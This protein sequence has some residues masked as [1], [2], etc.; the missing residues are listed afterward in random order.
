M[1][2]MPNDGGRARAFH[3]TALAL[4]AA[5]LLPTAASAGPV[6]DVLPDSVSAG[7]PFQ[8]VQ[9]VFIEDFESGDG[10]FTTGGTASWQYGQPVSPPSP[11]P[12]QGPSMWGTNLAGTYDNNEC[13]Y[14]QSPPIDLSAVPSAA[15]ETGARAARLLVRNWLH[16]ENR[17]D[18]GIVLGSSDGATWSP[19]TPAG[20]YPGTVL[21]AA[22]GC[23]GVAVGSGAFTSAA[24]PADDAWSLADLD[25]TAYLG[26]TVHLR[27]AFASDTSIVKRGWYVDDIAVQLGIGAGAT[28]DVP[29][30]P[31]EI[32][33]PFTPVTNAYAEDF[34]ASDGGWTADGTMAWEWGAPAEPPVTQPG[35]LNVWGTRLLTNY[36]PNECSAVT[37]PAI[38]LPAQAPGTIEAARLSMQLWRSLE[39][40]FDGA[41]LQVDDGSGW[42]RITPRPAYDRTLTSS[43]AASTRA[44]LGVTTGEPVWSGPSAEPAKDAWTSVSADVSAYLGKTIRIRIVMGSDADTEARGVYLDDVL[45]QLGAGVTTTVDATACADAPGWTS[46]GTNPSWCYGAAT[47]GP[48]SAKPV[49]ATNLEGQYNASECSAI[50]SPEIR[51]AAV[52]GLGALT[53]TF[54]HFMDTASSDDGG[55]VQI[56]KDGGASWSTVTPTGGYNTANLGASA[57][58]CVAPGA[59]TQPGWSGA[60]TGDAYVARDARIPS[61]LIGDTIRVRFLF[62]SGASTHDLGWYIRNVGFN[63]GAGSVPLLP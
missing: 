39:N 12:G 14:I 61:S 8:P 50:V 60:L 44:C 13:G 9:T 28:V 59:T 62:G 49:F 1:M 2:G 16:V 47:T 37:S 26:G 51:T 17:F 18:A 54:E 10:G 55:V 46:G 52:P 5:L 34:E 25:L 3:A 43:F 20:G 24:T 29:D 6:P 58:A 19:L 21:A 33:V 27:F 30:E 56:S 53:L 7:V 23:F 45:V 32:G 40:G 57:R 4:A 22:A 31:Q 15:P 38:S 35:S 48:F 42:R 11:A 63:R 41:V 36:L